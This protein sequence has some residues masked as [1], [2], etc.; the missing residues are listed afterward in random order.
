MKWQAKVY[1]KTRMS[2]SQ[3]NSWKDIREQVFERDDYTCM[4]CGNKKIRAKRT[5]TAHHIIPRNQDGSDDIRNLVTLCIKCHDFV[6][7]N[8][9]NTLKEIKNSFVDETL[10]E[11]IIQADNISDEAFD[12]P[13]WHS[14]VYG[15]GKN[16]NL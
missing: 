13:D 15:G 4:R 1:R 3:L 16:P 8:G 10:D 5:L 6:E 2:K 7:M 11:A 9:L 14:W 12:R